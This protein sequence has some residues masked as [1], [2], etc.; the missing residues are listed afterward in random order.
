MGNDYDAGLK[1]CVTDNRCLQNIFIYA[2]SIKNNMKLAVDIRMCNRNKC[3]FKSS[4]ERIFDN[5]DR[6]VEN[7]VCHIIYM[8]NI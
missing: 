8:S 7:T 1:I 3:P 4:V 6:R 5:V 2:M